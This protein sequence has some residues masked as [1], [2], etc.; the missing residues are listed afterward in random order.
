MRNLLIDGIDVYATYG[1]FITY[2]CYNNLISYP[3]L[4]KPILVNNWAEEDGE[5]V[6]LTSMVLDHKEFD[7]SF[8]TQQQDKVFVFIQ[9]LSAKTYHEFNFGDLNRVYTLRL[10][11][12]PNKKMYSRSE[13]FSL[14]F[15]DDYPMRRRVSGVPSSDMVSQRGYVLDDVDMSRY[16]VYVLDG[17]D[18]EIMKVPDVKINITDNMVLND[19]LKY[20]SKNVQL[21]CLMLA[22]NIDEFWHNYEALLF[23]L[24]QDDARSLYYDKLDEEYSCYYNNSKVVKFRIADRVWCQFTMSLTFTSF[25]VPIID[26]AILSSENGS[27]V[28]TEQGKYF[29]NLN[30]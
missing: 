3:A 22:K 29:I 15:A 26:D 9:M 4:K 19:A 2:G 1:I 5:D 7:L 13:I 20:H 25:G 21:P 24:T 27:G 8:A 28:I 14:R 30:V 18:A 16:G 6:D 23:A 17:S 12:Q 11:S 10:L